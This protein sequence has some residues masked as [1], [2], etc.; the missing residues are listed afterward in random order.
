MEELEGIQPKAHADADALDEQ[1]TTCP[2]ICKNPDAPHR[3]S[4]MM[5]P[6]M[7]MG[8][9]APS[10]TLERRKEKVLGQGRQEG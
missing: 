4:Q 6:N 1:H 10:S 5:M 2:R 3:I 9:W 7:E 8:P